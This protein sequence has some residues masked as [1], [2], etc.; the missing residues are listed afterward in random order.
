MAVAVEQPLPATSSLLDGDT[1]AGG[2]KGLVVSLLAI[3]DTNGSGR[4]S[5]GEFSEGASALGFHHDEK[6]WGSLHARYGDREQAM[7]QRAGEEQSL[8][9]NLIGAYFQNKFD[10]VLEAVMRRLLMAIMFNNER[11][12]AVD[13]RLRAVEAK[14]ESSAEREA[15]ERQHRANQVIRKWKHQHTSLA[16]DGW[17]EA[18]QRSKDLVQRTARRWLYAIAGNV[19]RRWVELVEERREMRATVARAV[20]RWSRGFLAGA[21]VAWSDKVRESVDNRNATLGRAMGWWLNR[22]LAGP[23]QIF[24]KS[25]IL[26]QVSVS[27][28]P[29][30]ILNEQETHVSLWARGRA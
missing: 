22:Q 16:F 13:A 20:G 15:R 23:A 4:L 1:D 5:K 7:E 26:D 18:V 17:K 21:F 9:L 6:A 27:I 24:D 29:S 12:V 11:S 30:S 19:W 2:V 28:E 14:L 10:P 8:D 3:F 25:D